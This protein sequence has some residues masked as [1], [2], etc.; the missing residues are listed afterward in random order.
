MTF[1]AGDKEEK[2]DRSQWLLGTHHKTCLEPG[3][4]QLGSSNSNQT[5]TTMQPSNDVLRYL[6]QRN[7]NLENVNSS[8]IKCGTATP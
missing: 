7:E 1:N 2:P 4:K 5:V 6:Y 8:F 3:K